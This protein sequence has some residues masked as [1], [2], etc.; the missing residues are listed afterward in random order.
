MD[1]VRARAPLSG[2]PY[3]R[4]AQVVA[5]VPSWDAAGFCV[6]CLSQQHPTPLHR[7]RNQPPLP[8]SSPQNIE[9]SY[10][11]M[12]DY[13]ESVFSCKTGELCGSGFTGKEF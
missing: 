11:A 7:R 12:G 8:I 4:A 10:R 3:T 9:G 1:G 6:F 2:A 5:V 13:M